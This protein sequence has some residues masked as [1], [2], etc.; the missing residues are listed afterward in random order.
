MGSAGLGTLADSKASPAFFWSFYVF[1]GFGLVFSIV[2][3]CFSA[4]GIIFLELLHNISY[5]GA[6]FQDFLLP[7]TPPDA[8]KTSQDR[9]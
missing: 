1:F 3:A 5:L 2:F 4:L 9:F 7:K 6:F 8:T